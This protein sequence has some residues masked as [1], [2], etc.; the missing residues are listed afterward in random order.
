[1]PCVNLANMR[2]Y[3]RQIATKR[4][5]VAAWSENLPTETIS[6]QG[7]KAPKASLP[8]QMKNGAK[9][10]KIKVVVITTKTI[11]AMRAQTLRVY[12]KFVN[13]PRFSDDGPSKM[14]LVA[15]QFRRRPSRA[16]LINAE[17]K[18][19]STIFGPVPEGHRRE[20]FHDKDNIWIWHEDWLDQTNQLHHMTVRYEVRP[21]GIYKKISAGRYI[22]LDGAEL[23]NFCRATHVYLFVIKQKL[24]C[25]A[26]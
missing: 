26:N 16:E 25:Y 15:R 24:Y 19:G 1:M 14:A 4:A 9:A 6:S 7:I 2:S 5:A 12:T 13:R 23:D 21:S 20:F 17:S 18:L 22:R 3:R 11:Q 8:R 10:A